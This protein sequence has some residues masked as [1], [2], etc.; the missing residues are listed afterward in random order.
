MGFNSGF[1]GLKESVYS[2]TSI[3]HSWISLFF[4]IAEFN[5]DGAN[6]SHLAVLCRPICLHFFM[7]CPNLLCRYDIASCIMW[8]LHT[9]NSRKT[10]MTTHTNK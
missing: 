9:R 1:K 4:T 10:G 8:V 5:V 3:H 6:L 2:E 7:K